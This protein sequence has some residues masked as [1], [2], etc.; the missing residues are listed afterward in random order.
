MTHKD[1]ETMQ[2]A[3]GILDAVMHFVDKEAR[4]AIYS[5]EQLLN[6]VLGGEQEVW[7]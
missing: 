6:E 5:A 2:K 4:L 3:I 7:K 1:R